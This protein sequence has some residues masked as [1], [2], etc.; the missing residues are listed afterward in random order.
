MSLAKAITEVEKERTRT[1][2]LGQ[3]L[4]QRIDE[5]HAITNTVTTV[6]ETMR[7]GVVKE[8]EAKDADLVSII[9]GDEAGN[10]AQP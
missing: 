3:R 5:L 2:E 9:E 10:A 4:L 8:F 7:A 6:L 1:H